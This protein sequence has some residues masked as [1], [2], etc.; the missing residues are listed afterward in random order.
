MY[1]L[2]RAGDRIAPWGTPF[3]MFIVRDF[4][5]LCWIWAVLPERKFDIHFLECGGKFVSSI[6]LMRLCLGTV[7]KALFMS[8]AISMVL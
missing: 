6:L 1:R 7:S 8:I 2:K 4:C 5:P 3:F